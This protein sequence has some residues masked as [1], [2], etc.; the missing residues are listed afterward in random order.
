MSDTDVYRLV[1]KSHDTG[2]H[3]MYSS[4]GCTSGLYSSLKGVKGVRTRRIRED[5]RYDWSNEYKI[6]KL[7]ST[8]VSVDEDGYY[9]LEWVDVDA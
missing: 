5:G 8:P 2:W 1:R 6:Q 9:G 7:E 3:V 4:V